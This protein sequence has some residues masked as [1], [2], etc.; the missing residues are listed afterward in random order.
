MRRLLIIAVL[1]LPCA[2]HAAW[3]TGWSHRASIEIDATLVDEAVPYVYVPLSNFDS[4]WWTAV[5]STDGRDIRVTESDGET[6]RAVYIFGFVDSGTTGTGGLLINVASYIS[7]SVN[8]TLY[9]YVGNGSATM[10]AVGDTY[11]RNAVFDANTAAF[12]FPGM[13][14]TDLT[15]S[16]FDL[17][18]VN[19]PTTAASDIEGL[20]AAD[21]TSASSQ[22]HKHEGGVVAPYPV[23]LETRFYPD[24]NANGPQI[25]TLSNHTNYTAL[26]SI[27]QRASGANILIRTQN[28]GATADSSAVAISTW[29]GAW[30]T[31]DATTG[32]TRT[33]VDGA[34]SGTSAT[35][36]ATPTITRLGIAALQNAGGWSSYWDG[37]VAYAAIHDVARSANYISTVNNYWTNASF[38]T[39]GT[40][41]AAPSGGGE[42]DWL[43]FTAVTSS[44]GWTN[45]TNALTSLASA[46]TDDIPDTTSSA[47]LILTDL[48]GAASEVTGQTITGIEFEIS[49]TGEDGGGPELYDDVL[50][51]YDAG[52]VGTDFGIGTQWTDSSIVTRHY[53]GAGNM[54]GTS[55]VDTDIT[56]STF[57][58]TMTFL[59]DGNQPALMSVYRVRVKIYYN[60]GG[61]AGD[62]T[63]FFF[64][65]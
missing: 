31:R 63:N 5:N 59:S 38:S 24:T 21:Y 8:V 47:A 44:T 53:G 43:E 64:G 45:P 16:G 25:L 28:A 61:E 2:V 1:I 9:A 33:Y 11:G 19:T 65:G 57:G 60:G 52:A 46:A 29:R 48:D 55:L 18:A 20:T 13:T 32:T 23:S 56:A 41:E 42:T 15:G 3:L 26:D 50:R 30:N 27:S 36:I 49:A 7:T 4:T 62:E 40:T 12:Y 22:Y 35:T 58:I 39:H 14:T 10:P 51:V 54:L 34:A 37:K 17:T 6:E